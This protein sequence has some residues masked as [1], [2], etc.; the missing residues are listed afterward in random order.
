MVCWAQPNLCPKCAHAGLG[1]SIGE[2]FFYL[3]WGALAMMPRRQSH[4]LNGVKGA[5]RGGRRLPHALAQ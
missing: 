5:R 3:L 4:A 1:Q 2:L